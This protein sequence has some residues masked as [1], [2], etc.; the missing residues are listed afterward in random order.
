MKFTDN[1]DILT[2]SIQRKIPNFLFVARQNAVIIF[3][4]RKVILSSWIEFEVNLLLIGSKD[5]IS[6]FC[7]DKFKEKFKG[8]F[9]AR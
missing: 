8:E 7:K 4:H 5:M 2:T 6:L 3:I 1:P 9:V